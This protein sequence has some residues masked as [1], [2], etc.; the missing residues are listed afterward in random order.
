M[1]SVAEAKS[2]INEQC[3]Q[4]PVIKKSLNDSSGC[5]LANDVISIADIP[6]FNQSAMDGYAFQYDDWLNNKEL[7]I[8]GELAAGAHIKIKLEQGHAIRIFTGA[9]VPEGADTVVMQERT[10]IMNGQLIIDDLNLKIGNAI[11]LKGSEIKARHC[12]LERGTYLSPAAIGFL[13]SIGID[14]VEVFK[15]PVVSIIVTGNEL[16]EPGTKL[17]H[18]QVYECNSFALLAA[19]KQL[20]INDIYVFRAKDDK[21]EIVHMLTKALDLADIVLLTGGV[22]VGDYDFVLNAADSLGIKK[23][24]H[25]IKQKPGKPL[26][27]GKLPNKT[28]F[29][30]PGN[31]SSVLTCFYEYVIPALNRLSPSIPLLQSIYVPLN[32]EIN[33]AIGLTHFLKATHDGLNVMPLDAQESYKLSSF[34]KAN[35]LICLDEN[36][37]H[38]KVG[39]IVEIHLLPK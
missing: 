34:A 18:G 13:A 10:S 33:K 15:T 25:R 26:Y 22:S 19:L 38:C 27:F 14:Q 24:F 4:L 28:I 12:A 16:K 20:Q 8:K 9:P 11:R 30:L 5:L 31:P 36:T 23:L 17:E 1:I 6:P 3:S 21:D 32:K 7:K 29:G 2:I 37:T 35:C 39:S